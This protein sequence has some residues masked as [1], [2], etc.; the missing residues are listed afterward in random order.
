[1]GK[2]KRKKEDKEEK[3]LLTNVQRLMDII[4]NRMDNG[5]RKPVMFPENQQETA[6]WWIKFL[7]PRMKHE[8]VKDNTDQYQE[9]IA[10]CLTIFYKLS[11]ADQGY[12][13]GLQQRGI[14]WRGD[15]IK[16]MKTRAKVDMNKI[17]KTKLFGMMKT[18]IARA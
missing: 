16:F 6:Q 18:I 15:S 7:E 10:D 12:L 17:D 3:V 2:F 11:E 1:M 14:W 13:Y 8:I 5:I 9:R 4:N